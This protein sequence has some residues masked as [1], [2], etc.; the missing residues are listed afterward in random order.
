MLLTDV[1]RCS[2]CFGKGL[3]LL[4]PAVTQQAG[5]PPGVVNIIPGYGPTA[6]AAISSHMDIDKVAFTGSTEVRR[7]PKP[8]T[9]GIWRR[10]H[11]CDTSFG[12]L[13]CPLLFNTAGCRV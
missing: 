3:M 5:F 7:A 8:L 13:A 6:G 9:L 1:G 12:A 2:P 11:C 10:S 4:S